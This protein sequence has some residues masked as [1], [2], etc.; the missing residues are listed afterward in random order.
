[1]ARASAREGE[2]GVCW[3]ARRPTQDSV[4]C[5]G[6]KGGG[7]KKRKKK[8]RGWAEGERERFP[9]YFLLIFLL[10]ILYLTFY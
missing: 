8:R 6:G 1:M 2:R 5:A 10:S 3:A 9:F 4:G 7:G